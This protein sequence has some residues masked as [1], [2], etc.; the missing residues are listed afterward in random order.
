M[1][2]VDTILDIIITVMKSSILK[3]PHDI[4]VL[5][6]S[7]IQSN[8][9]NYSETFASA[10]GFTNHLLP[11]GL[12]MTLFGTII[13]AEVSLHLVWKGFKYILNLFRGSGG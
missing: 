12:I 1:S 5:P 9:A 13:I 2:L 6:I 7:T 11:I 4:S 3:L 8:I 10:Y